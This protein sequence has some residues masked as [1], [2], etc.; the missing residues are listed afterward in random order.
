MLARM[1]VQTAESPFDDLFAPPAGVVQTLVDDAER[2]VRLIQRCVPSAQ[3]TEWFDALHAQVPWQAQRRPM[4]DRIV[5][6]PRLLASYQ[7][8]DAPEA[9]AVTVLLRG[10]RDALRATFS[11]R[12]ETRDLGEVP[13]DSVGLNFYRDGRDSV[14]MHNDT[15]R[16]LADGW[17]IVVLSLGGTRRMALRAKDG[18]RA[19]LGFDLR[20]GDVV[21][22]SH[23][24]QRT[25]DHGIPKTTRVVGPRI[26]LAFRVR[27]PT[28]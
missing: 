22:M 21:A 19:S 2:G 17:P 20:A 10:M 11:S 3:A 24:S 14:A 25:H 6:V 23:A 5:D 4:Y 18:A 7:L 1:R 26:S 15:L 13:F 8:G 16:H 27:A 28:A 9:D 12:A